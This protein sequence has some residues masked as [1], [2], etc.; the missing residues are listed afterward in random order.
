MSFSLI[1]KLGLDTSDY[2]KGLARGD[3]A[4][5]QFSHKMEGFAKKQEK[6]L[7][8]H[9]VGA[10]GVGAIEHAVLGSLEKGQKIFNQ[11]ANAGVPVEKYQEMQFAAEQTGRDLSDVLKLTGKLPADIQEAIDRFREMGGA[12]PFQ[13]IS[14]MARAAADI[15]SSKTLGSRIG[16]WFAQM[17]GA[18]AHLGT[19]LGLMYY[20][21]GLKG[22]G[23]LT[24]NSSLIDQ[25]DEIRAGILA[26][27]QGS[28]EDEALN[29]FQARKLSGKR[30]ARD[31]WKKET[32]EAVEQVLAQGQQKLLESLS[33]PEQ[34][35]GMQKEVSE[36]FAEAQKEKPGDRKDQLMRRARV[37]QAELAVL[38]ATPD[39]FSGAEL[40]GRALSVLDPLNKIGGFAQGRDT[41]L[42]DRFD[43]IAKATEETAANT[44]SA[45]NPMGA[46]NAY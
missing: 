26:E 18:V 1:G 17:P 45:Q 37:K 40:A 30:S 8:K 27:D 42:N 3:V 34:E 19:N 11:A 14:R 46:T 24:G 36:L 4:Y 16:S 22:V 44:R 29:R 7:F 28:I 2:E 5:K 43:R 23:H 10:L 20:G 6:F 25:A 13:E 9:L 15:Q 21:A 32:R 31:K 12:I 35:A 38:R 41:V 39:K 33:R